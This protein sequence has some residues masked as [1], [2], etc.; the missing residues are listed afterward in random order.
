MDKTHIIL[1][2]ISDNI[3]N[4]KKKAVNGKIVL[5]QFANAALCHLNNCGYLIHNSQVKNPVYQVDV[6]VKN[7]ETKE[8]IIVPRRIIP[9]RI[10]LRNMALYDGNREI[11]GYNPKNAG[12][13][14]T[15]SPIHEGKVGGLEFTLADVPHIYQNFDEAT[16]ITFRLYSGPK[17]GQ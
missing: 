12:K 7:G 16:T 14:I 11:I 10:E 1:E 15:M 4:T 2:L 8:L 17:T 3:F 9:G 13:L 5:Y 6:D